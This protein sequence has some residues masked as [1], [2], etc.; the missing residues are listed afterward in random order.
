MNRTLVQNKRFYW[1]LAHTNLNEIEK[2]AWVY[3]HTGNRTAKSSEMTFEEMDALLDDLQAWYNSMNRMRRKIFFRVSQILLADACVSEQVCL[4]Y[5][6]AIVGLNLPKRE[7]LND[8]RKEELYRI[9]QKLDAIAP[10]QQSK[11]RQAL[12][13]LRLDNENN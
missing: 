8:Y 5:I 1:L 10:K 7:R 13:V 2:A 12:K 9:L 6:H 4:A 3:E 11:Y